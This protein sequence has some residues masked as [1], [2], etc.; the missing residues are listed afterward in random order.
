MLL[1]GTPGMG[2]WI[3]ILQTM[4]AEVSACTAI[5]GEEGPLKAT[6]T[7]PQCFQ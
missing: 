3:Y 2:A 5:F 4:N 7:Q 1:A 6:K